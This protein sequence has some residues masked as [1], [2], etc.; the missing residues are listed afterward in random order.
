[1]SAI[2]PRKTGKGRERIKDAVITLLEIREFLGTGHGCYG[3]RAR[4]EEGCDGVVG[5]RI[6]AISM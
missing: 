3:L 1:M 5:P 6:A 4:R 2:V